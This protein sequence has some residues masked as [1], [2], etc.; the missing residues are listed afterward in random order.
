M[1][2]NTI[3]LLE[4]N[5]ENL[6]SLGLAMKNKTKRARGDERVLEGINSGLSSGSCPEGNRAG[7]RADR[8]VSEVIT[9]YHSTLTND[10]V[11][12]KH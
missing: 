4:G 9:Y 7:N 10:N 5:I 3:N 8:V 11:S 2:C 12:V 1:Y 6:G